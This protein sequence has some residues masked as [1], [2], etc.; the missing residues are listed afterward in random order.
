MENRR[1]FI[2]KSGLFLAL[3]ALPVS[4]F[5]KLIGLSKKPESVVV[6]LY[7]DTA[8]IDNR[9]VNASCNFGQDPS[10]FQRGIYY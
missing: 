10:Y 9:N 1:S 3:S 2:K 6:R 8:R 5:S 4:A 7:V